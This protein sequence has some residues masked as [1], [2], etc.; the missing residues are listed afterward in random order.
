MGNEESLMNSIR[1]LTL[2]CGIALIG[3]AGA[4]TAASSRQAQPSGDSL[5]FFE[6]QVRPLLAERCYSCHSATSQRGGLRL[7]SRA[8]VLKGGAHG[9]ALVPSFPEKSLLL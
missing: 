1:I 4:F 9:P 7:D 6:T 8:T 3:L 5:A 2:S